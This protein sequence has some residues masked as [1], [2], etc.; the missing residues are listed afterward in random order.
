MFTLEE[1]GELR[2]LWLKYSLKCSTHSSVLLFAYTSVM[3]LLA[4]TM[5]E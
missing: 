4:T 5:P 3:P 1:F 2:H